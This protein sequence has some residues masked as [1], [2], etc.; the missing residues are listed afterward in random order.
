LDA[1]YPPKWVIIARRFTGVSVPARLL[2]QGGDVEPAQGDVHASPAIAVRD[3]VRAAGGSDIDLDTDHVR[4]VIEM[5]PLDV[6]VL[7][8]YL[9]VVAQ[10]AGERRQP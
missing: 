5:Q 10:I 8:H 3:L 7:D 4:L 6:L 9:V 2:W 1:D